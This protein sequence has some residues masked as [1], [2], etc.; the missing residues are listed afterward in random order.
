MFAGL[1][2]TAQQILRRRI[3]PRVDHR[4]LLIKTTSLLSLPRVTASCLPS[5]D[6]SKS[7]ICPDSKFVIRFGGPPLSFCRQMLETP[8]RVNTYSTASPPGAQRGSP[9]NGGQS[10]WRNGAPPPK[11]ITCS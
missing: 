10:N 5:R 9:A 1:A 4:K 8:F 2:D 7:K 11:G 6:Q 3:E